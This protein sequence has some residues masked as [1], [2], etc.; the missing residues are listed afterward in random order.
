MHLLAMVVAAGAINAAISAWS[1]APLDFAALRNSSLVAT[2]L[3]VAI[4]LFDW[5]GWRFPAL[6]PWFVAVPR[7]R[8]EWDVTGDIDWVRPQQSARFPGRLSIKQT[9]FSIW[10][11]IDWDDGAHMHFLM[12]APIVAREDGFCAFTAVYELDPNTP[13]SPSVTRRAGFF[14]H[15]AQ[16]HPQAV[17]LFYSTTDDQIGRIRLSARKKMTLWR[18]LMP[19]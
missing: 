3:G 16:S 1:G 11:G 9:Y 8:G 5:W 19:Y 10:M 17:T 6:Y 15:C 13:G 7:I 14:F 2:I 12:K 4:V 18:R